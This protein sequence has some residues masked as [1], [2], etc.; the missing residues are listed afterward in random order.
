MSD[1]EKLKA[2]WKA[3]SVQNKIMIALLALGSTLIGV[4][5]NIFIGAGTF[6]LVIVLAATIDYAADNVSEIMR[7][8]K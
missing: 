8:E 2:R 6:F 7:R 1:P 4:G 5:S 3:I